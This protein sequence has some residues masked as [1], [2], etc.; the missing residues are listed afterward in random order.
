MLKGEIIRECVRE[1]VREI[2]G[3]CVIESAR[4]SDDPVR[5]QR[6]LN[7]LL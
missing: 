3:E 6:K 4:E 7:S 2:V 1:I 5:F